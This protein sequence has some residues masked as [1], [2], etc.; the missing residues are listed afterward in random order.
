MIAELAKKKTAEVAE[1][2]NKQIKAN[3][4]KRDLLKKVQLLEE[5]RAVKINEL[6]VQH[7]DQITAEHD[8]LK[9]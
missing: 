8:K 3:N 2:V 5:V 4:E 1:V 9:K 6:V 7:E